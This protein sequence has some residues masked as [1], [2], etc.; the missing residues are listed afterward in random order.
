MDII[1]FQIDTAWED[2]SANFERIG[3]LVAGCQVHSDSLLV[4]PELSTVG[5]SMNVEAVAES[6]HGE[7]FQFFSGLAK[8]KG[9]HVLA[10]ISG[11]DSESGLGLNEAVCFAPD[12]SE[13][14]RYR[15]VHP[16]PLSNESDYYRSGTEAV[17]FEINDWKVAP[18]ICYDLRFPELF[19]AAIK[20]GAEVFL[21]IANWP[22]LRE[23]HWITL[24]RARAIENQAYVAGVNR[25]GSDP[26]LNYS[27]A[28]MIVNPLGE[29]IVQSGTEPGVLQAT[30]DK[31]LLTDWRKNFPALKGM[32]I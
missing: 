28:S 22:D 24:L 7:T 29:I 26:T 11:K 32:K 25:C 9:C 14:S 18:M 27:G 12:G 2:P 30:L 23:D 1:T 10:G 4:F 31:N 6:L 13:I 16:F 19:R 20:Q 5:F 17:V 21:V 15:K 8:E 3:A